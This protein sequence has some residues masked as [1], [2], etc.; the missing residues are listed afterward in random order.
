[1]GEGEG[2]LYDCQFEILM[3]MKRSVLLYKVSEYKS[4]LFM[5]IPLKRKDFVTE[6]KLI[7]Y[8]SKYVECLLIGE[9]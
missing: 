9:K 2:G 8:Y 1:M 7:A 4:C 6:S 3:R 5:G